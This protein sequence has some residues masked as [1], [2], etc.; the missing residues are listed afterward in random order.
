MHLQLAEA[1]LAF[2]QE[3]RDFLGEH[4]T[5][6][7][8]AAGATRTGTFCDLAPTAKW[9]ATLHRKG[10]V[11]PDWPTEHGGTG[12][13]TTQRH[14]FA[15]ECAAAG[16]P[17][18]HSFGIRMCGP[19][20]I[21]FGTQEQQAY[22]LPKIL[23]GE[24]RW[25][26]G[27]SE[28]GS[29]SDLA[30]LQT[31]AVSDGDDYVVNGTKIWTSLAHQA[32]HIFCLVRTDPEAKP[33]RGITF[34][35]IDRNTPGLTMK[36]I[37]NIAG[38]HEFNQVF[39]DDVRVPKSQRIGA[40]NEGWTVAKYLLEFE[41]GGNYAAGLWARLKW[42]QDLAT[43]TAVQEAGFGRKLAEVEIEISA[44]EMQEQRAISALALGESPGAAASMIKLQG[45]VL[46]QRLDELAI[47]ALG[48]LARQDDPRAAV[49]M[50][51]YLYDRSVT[52]FG[53][54]SEIQRNIM[55]KTALGL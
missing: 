28:P 52:I 34:L 3:V 1:D 37:I 13:T 30:S 33:Q 11:A 42:V 8:R 12:W 55:A 21:R 5:D 47:E 40:E 18:T 26:Q 54:T 46:I 24:H 14:I 48:P 35:L 50:G 20:I 49:A 31:R 17:G 25:C 53:G 4:L 10:W 39:F 19:V 27:Y 29:G 7:L 32:T 44:V 16:A 15:S 2:R 36:P 41:R 6:D 22:Y 51:R 23:S 43:E 38:D 9:H 45:S